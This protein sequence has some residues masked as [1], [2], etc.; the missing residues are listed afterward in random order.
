MRDVAAGP[1]VVRF[2]VFE[3]DLRAGELRKKGLRLRLQEQPLQVLALLLQQ[4][5]EVVGREELRQKVWT[6]GII[7]DFDHSLN[8]T[9]NKL[10]KALGDSADTPRFI[11]T[12]PRRGYR[13][14]CPVN[15]TAEAAAVPGRRAW[16]RRRW[17]ILAG[18]LALLLGLAA[19]NVGEVRERLLG[20]PVAIEVKSIAVLPLRNLSAE[21]DQEYFAEGMTEALVTQLGQLGT[22][23]V[24][25][26]Q[27]V[28]GYRGTTKS[29]P[30]IAR[31]LKVGAI[32][33]GTVL[34]SGERIRITANLVQAA[35]ERH[36]WAETFEFDR[37]DILAVQSEVARGVAYHIRIKLTPQQE[38]RLSTSVR[39][40]PEA[41]EAY[42]V[43]RVH[44]HKAGPRK[45]WKSAKDYFEKAIEIDP[46]FAPAYA[47]LA[48]LYVRTGRGTVT[49]DSRGVYWDG[50]QQARHLAEKA[51][52]LDDRLAEAHTALGRIAEVEWNWP[53]AG[54]QYRRAVELNP[55]YPLARVWYAMH[56]LAWERF[57]EGSF[58]AKR[59]QQLDPASPFVNTWAAAAHGYAGRTEDAFAS[60][61]RAAELDPTSWE[62]SQILSRLYMIQEAYAAAIAEL[63]RARTFNPSEPEV[64]GMLAYAHGRAGQR[65][66]ALALIGELKRVVAEG[67]TPFPMAWA[68]AGLGDKDKAFAWL[69]QCYEERRIRMQ[70]LNVDPLLVPL[71]S[72]PRFDDLARRVGL[73][74]K[75]PT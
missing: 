12:L 8:T 28:L 39:V 60:A 35:P 45:V 33:E 26:H 52:E 30:E 2:S 29:L 15:G 37:R 75:K 20:R 49:R 51:L 19:F 68:Y 41:Y 72:D 23:D 66:K 53:E 32:L 4:P 64:L 38:A 14:I 17:A 73:P 57:E 69:E 11:E 48:E 36:L 25:S 46:S 6:G 27:S 62:A 18:P 50:R 7:V 24:I 74:I 67:E 21:R 31:E 55:S 13:F 34:R 10:R 9:I 40:H 44:T 22:L 71:R 5:G 56:L 42:L 70:W 3:L 58:H 1:Q 59:A 63:E 65:E 43:G 54:R 47:S 16:W 61:R